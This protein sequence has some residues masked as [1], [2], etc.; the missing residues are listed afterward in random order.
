MA[1][2]YPGPVPLLEIALII[3]IHKY[4]KSGGGVSRV[5]MTRSCPSISS[6]L[7]WARTTAP[8]SNNRALESW[9]QIGL[10]SGVFSYG[11][12]VIISKGSRRRADKLP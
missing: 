2:S 5:R 4:K 11:W 10:V 8:S 3:L 6:L 1:L 7:P 9:C 12:R